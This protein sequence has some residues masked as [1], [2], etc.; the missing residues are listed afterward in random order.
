MSTTKLERR[1]N[2][3]F[4]TRDQSLPITGGGRRWRML[5]D[6]MF[7]QGYKGRSIEKFTATLLPIMGGGREE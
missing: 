1:I 3:K 4:E 7:F 2:K 6:H 5:G